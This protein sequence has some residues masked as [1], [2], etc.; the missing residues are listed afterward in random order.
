MHDGP[1]TIELTERTLKHLK[2]R[3]H[4]GDGMKS[5]RE[6][7]SYE[8]DEVQ[9]PLKHSTTGATDDAS[10]DEKYKDKQGTTPSEDYVCLLIFYPVQGIH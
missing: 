4:G 7:A 8:R 5:S 2:Q 10:F 6:E 1:P 9:G 3:H